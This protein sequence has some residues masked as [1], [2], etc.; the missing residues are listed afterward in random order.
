MFKKWKPLWSYDIDKTENWLREM[1]RKG[2]RLNGVNRLTRLFSF[3]TDATKEIDYHI[4]FD[5]HQQ[6][7]S[8]TLTN[9]GWRKGVDTGNWSILENDYESIDLFPSRDNL[10]KRNRLHSLIWRIIS[11]YY[12]IQLALPVFLVMVVL[13]AGGEA[14]AGASSYW[15][16]T[17]LYFAQVIGVLMLTMIMTRKLRKFERKYYDME[18]DLSSSVGKTFAKWKPNWMISL[19]LTEKWLEDMSLKG[20][21]LVKVQATRFVFEKG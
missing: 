15:I 17:F 13:I 4:S 9:A 5:K 1:A 19:D 6:D 18:V 7:L 16:F 20:N 2:H 10:I 8:P 12:G 21:H 11:I 3:E 14:N